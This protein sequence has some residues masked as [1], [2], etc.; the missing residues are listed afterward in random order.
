MQEDG[1]RKLGARTLVVARAAGVDGVVKPG[2]QPDGV[3]VDRVTGELV[4]DV[5]DRTQMVDVVI[6]PMRSDQRLTFLARHH[7]PGE[8][9]PP[10]EQ[11]VHLSSSHA[12]GEHCV[13]PSTVDQVGKR[14]VLIGAVCSGDVARAELQRR[15][16]GVRVQ[17]QI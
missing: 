10:L 17:P 9:A 5:Q 7:V 3:G 12:Q 11:I 15:D 6:T 1:R 16:A 4:D 14:D 2:S 8:G 13:A